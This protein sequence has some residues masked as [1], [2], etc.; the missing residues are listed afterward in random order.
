MSKKNK[1]LRKEV[2]V[3]TA[4]QLLRCVQTLDGGFNSGVSRRACGGDTLVAPS[5]HSDAPL[6]STPP[7]PPP[8]ST[9]AR[10]VSWIRSV[11]GRYHS[12]CARG[13]RQGRRT[14]RHLGESQSKDRTHTWAPPVECTVSGSDSGVLLISTWITRYSASALCLPPSLSPNVCV[15]VSAHVRACGDRPRSWLYIMSLRRQPDALV[16]DTHIGNP[17]TRMEITFETIGRR[18]PCSV[19]LFTQTSLCQASLI[20]FFIR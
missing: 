4:I 20:R 8:P 13:Q 17:S 12:C 14:G 16:Q 11:L 3:K 18:P 6:A 5:V 19:S 10:S 9:L 15:C 1:S 7:P 2:V